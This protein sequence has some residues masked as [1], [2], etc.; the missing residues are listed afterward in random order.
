MDDKDYKFDTK[1]VHAGQHPDPTTGS[2][3]TPIYQT[4]T[5]VFKS[6]EQGAARFEG[7]EPGYIYTRLGNP[8]VRALELNLAT[9]EGGEDA[10]AAGSGMAAITA[11][12]MSVVNEGDHIVSS[13]SIYGGTDK[14]FR[15][16][17][18]RYGVKVSFVDT[19]DT[20]NIEAAITDRTKI[21]YFESPSNPLMKLTD[22]K[23]IAKIGKKHDITTMIDN[24]FMSPYNQ[25]PIEHGID[26]VIH[27]LTKSLSG[28]SDMVG[29]I[30]ISTKQFIT[31][32]DPT[33]KNMG[34]TMGAFDAWL[35]LRGVKTL[36]VR[37]DRINENAMKIAMFLEDHPKIDHVNYPGLESHPQHDLASEQADD[38]GGMMSFELK[39]GIEA[40]KTLMNSV[41][42]CSLAVS[43]G[44][45]ETLISHP[46]SMTHSIIP[47][48][49]R[50]R[51]GL[52]DG[53]VRLSV[54]I[55]AAEDIISD[56]EQALD[57]V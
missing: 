52:T 1:A 36:H 54:G 48:E 31:K 2:V 43:L 44:A 45:V 25:R 55:E 21:I 56:L 16:I 33:F 47:R 9:L 17:L 49:E 29:G 22:I 27:S 38:Y 28:H 19:T 18:K 30:V 5:F 34:A 23:A 53:L 42:L 35:T 20:R 12:V 50:L 15:D 14:L 6:A 41:K 40:G 39:G 3:V 51:S 8:T 4:S 26:V 13:D 46:A 37:W 11:A 10:R 24:T 32:M 7:K 57:K